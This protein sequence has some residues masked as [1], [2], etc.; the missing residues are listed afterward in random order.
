MLAAMSRDGVRASPQAPPV[1]RCDA[2]AEKGRAVDLG[3]T[4]LD[5]ARAQGMLQPSKADRLAL[6]EVQAVRQAR[7]GHPA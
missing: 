4:A 7:D 6:E 5:D 3:V 2:E 1:S